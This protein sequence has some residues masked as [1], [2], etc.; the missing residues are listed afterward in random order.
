MSRALVAGHVIYGALWPPFPYPALATGCQPPSSQQYVGG[1]EGYGFG[2]F[3]YNNEVETHTGTGMI[4]AGSKPTGQITISS[5]NPWDAFD[6]PRYIEGNANSGIVFLGPNTYPPAT[7]TAQG[8]TLDDVLVR[9]N[10]KYGV[11]L[12]SVSNYGNYTGFVNNACISGNSPFGDTSP[13]N[14]T[15][16]SYRVPISDAIYRDGSCPNTGWAAALVPA[17]S[18][19]PGWSW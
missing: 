11:V 17:A 9:N 7:S 19:V 10:T 3:F 18:H 8:V 12:D 13:L 5:A 16:L 2:H 4:F 14:W 1:I 15:T 6:T